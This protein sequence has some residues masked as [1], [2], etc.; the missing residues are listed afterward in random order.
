MASPERRELMDYTNVQ[1][2]PGNLLASFAMESR[3][4]HGPATGGSTGVS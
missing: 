2:T 4:V 1:G 3:H